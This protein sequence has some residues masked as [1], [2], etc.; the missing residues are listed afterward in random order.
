MPKR[1]NYLAHATLARLFRADMNVKPDP[2]G[3]VPYR[4]GI[5]DGGVRA[6]PGA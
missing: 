6:R 1:S 4:I 3:H 2:N 5:R